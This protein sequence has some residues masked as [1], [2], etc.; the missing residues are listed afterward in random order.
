MNVISV[1]N[2]TKAFKVLQKKS[3]LKDIFFPKYQN[4]VAVNGISFKVERGESVALLG[5]NGAGKTTIIKM[6]TGLI[7]PSS[8]KIIINGH[9]PSERKTIFLKEIGL[10]MGNKG[11]MNWDLTPI[12]SLDLLQKIYDIDRAQFEKD[13]SN[14]GKLL[15]VTEKFNTPVRK[16]SLGERMKMEIVASIIHRPNIL[17]LDEPTIGLDILSKHNIRE[18]L[19]NLPK[20]YKTTLILTSH[21]IDNV[22]K[23]CDR[24]IIISKGTIIFNGT[25]KELKHTFSQ[26]KILTITSQNKLS[27]VPSKYRVVEKDTKQ[28]KIE[29]PSEKLS[30][31]IKYFVDN[32]QVLD[33]DISSIPLEE[34]VKR[35]FTS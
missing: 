3:L 29:T 1:K 24:I 32:Y 25:I 9:I 28:I 12:Q 17:F 27:N 22:E 26:S 34:M 18:L 8:G 5:P 30:S 23:I 35:Y 33:I 31:A 20:L 7:Y 15:D 19:R 16:L 14:L 2:L 21:D 10:V 13:I 11:G 6:L 4:I